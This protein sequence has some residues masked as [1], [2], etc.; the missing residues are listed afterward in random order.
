MTDRV[1]KAISYILVFK[2]KCRFLTNNLRNRFDE[3]FWPHPEMVMAKT[4][5][6]LWP[7]FN[8]VMCDLSVLIVALEY[9]S[10]Q[11]VW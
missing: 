4:T 7:K 11:I 5:S 1:F 2:R 10:A 6:I 3:E 9:S 8:I